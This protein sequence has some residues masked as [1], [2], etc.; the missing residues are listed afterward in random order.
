MEITKYYFI[1]ASKEFLITKEPM[2]EVLRERIQHYRK[3][4]KRIDFWIL[5]NPEFLQS[6]LYIQLKNKFPKN[7]LVIIS[8]NKIFITWLKLRL[9]NVFVSEFF[10]PTEQILNPLGFEMN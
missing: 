7:C 10:A 3:E 1:L 8:T 6:S 2:E 9:Q 5:P 4:K